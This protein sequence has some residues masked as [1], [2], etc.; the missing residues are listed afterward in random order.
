MKRGIYEEGFSKDFLEATL[1]FMFK[2][3][4]KK[5]VCQSFSFRRNAPLQSKFLLESLL[6]T[7]LGVHP[8]KIGIVWWNQ[9]TCKALPT[10]DS[11]VRYI[12][13]ILLLRINIDQG[14]TLMLC[15]LMFM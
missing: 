8:S 7:E 6:L 12:C 15:L 1:K 13:T 11:T 10:M 5:P 2:R 9:N 3:H 14:F 4:N